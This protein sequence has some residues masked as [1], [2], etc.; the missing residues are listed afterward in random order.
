MWHIICVLLIIGVILLY[1]RKELKENIADGLI[2]MSIISVIVLMP[3]LFV[4][5]YFEKQNNKN[6]ATFSYIKEQQA[7]NDSILNN[8]I[9]DI[10]D[11]KIDSTHTVTNNR[12]DSLILL[13]NKLV[14]NIA[15]QI[16]TLKL[17]NESRNIPINGISSVSV[18]TEK[19]KWWFIANPIL[20]VE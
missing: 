16:E 3:T 4:I 11:L 5:Y 14:L 18:K 15:T 10:K 1:K 19:Y 13:N 2:P 7:K 8:I 17:A 12:T 20:I 6:E 9:R